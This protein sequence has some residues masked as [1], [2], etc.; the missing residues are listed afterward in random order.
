VDTRV[1][2]LDNTLL[3]REE[4]SDIPVPCNTTRRAHL[5]Y[6]SGVAML[7][8]VDVAQWTTAHVAV[9]LTRVV[10]LGVRRHIH[11]GLYV[12]LPVATLVVWCVV[13]GCEV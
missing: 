4:L 3:S 9:W 2:L 10:H 11:A 6:K 13:M 8:A 12:H 5:P 7:D 1:L